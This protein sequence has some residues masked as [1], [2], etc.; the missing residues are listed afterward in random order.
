V[1]FATI[2]YWMARYSLSAENYVKYVFVIVLINFTCASMLFMISTMTK[3]LASATLASSTIILLMLLFGG[4]LLNFN[5]IPVWLGWIRYLSFP[6][7]A[8]EALLGNE[9]QGLSINIDLSVT[10]IVSGGVS[11]SGDLFI[12][13]FAI[14]PANYWRN[15]GIIIG[16]GALFLIVAYIVLRTRVRYKA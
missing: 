3:S 11:L 13:A 15:V 7:F 10:S 4:L 12:E 14:N 16:Y 8:Y 9:L 1:I 5:T 6:G 2:I